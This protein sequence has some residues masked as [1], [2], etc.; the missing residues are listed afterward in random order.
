MRYYDNVVEIIGN[1]P[2]VRLNSVTEGI[3]ATVLA[4]VE[5]M[6]P[7]G[8]VKDRIALRMVEDAE[9][10]GLLKPG[11]TIVEPTSGNT[12]VGLALVAQR[13][14]YKCVFVCPDKVSEDKQN[15]L[16][17]YGA[18]VVVCPTAV[19]PEDPRSYYNVSAQL[20]RDIPGAWKPDQYSNPA[21]PR[22]HYEETGPELWEQTGGKITHFVAGV[23]TGGTITGVGRYL[24]ER[25]PVR[26]IGADPEG[27]VY[28]GGTGRPYLVEGVGEDFW[29]TAYDP[30]VT[31]E[32]IK[33]SDSDSFEMTRRLAREEGLLVGGSC[34][35]A[36]VA[37]LEVARK[38]GPDDVIV[39]LL[40]DGG[41]GY[42]SKIF[43]DRWMARYG[44]LRTPGDAPTVAD[45]LA[46]KGAEIPPLVHVHPTETV[47]DAIDYMR[48]YGVSQLP[49]LKAEPPV[50][51]GEVAG[52]I[53]E[54]ALLDALF[55]GQ[56]H[57][58]DTIE[59]HMTEPLPMIGGGESVSEA[60]AL[61]EKADAAM[62]LVDGKPAGVL[63]RQDLLAHLS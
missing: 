11:G 29:P 24:K 4:K 34:G 44:F 58:H 54:K 14:G 59:R 63:T 30:K 9:A 50:V 47:R 36:V 18:E 62:V 48:E 16:R 19:A 53:S 57:L 35:M 3:S 12:G 52:S 49:V 33:V 40:P 27:S 17:A 5:Y 31:D 1:T 56:A 10:A 15:V 20:T 6:N 8:S 60:V 28:S 42:L 45:A 41:R 13:R 46:A 37:A 26:V 51:T 7:G 23:G 25:G 38:A 43:N 32:V 61:L 39:V 22:S 2:L 55:T 21:N